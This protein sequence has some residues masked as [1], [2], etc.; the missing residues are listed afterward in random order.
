MLKRICALSLAAG[1]C[2]GSVQIWGK[3]SG[4]YVEGDVNG[5]G[6]FSIADDIRRVWLEDIQICAEL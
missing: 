3:T 2:A 4:S 1:I 5:D 6:S